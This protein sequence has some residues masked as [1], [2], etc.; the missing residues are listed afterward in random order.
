MRRARAGSAKRR[1]AKSASKTVSRAAPKTRTSKTLTKTRTSKTLTK[2][3][4]SGIASKARG[5]EY[6]FIVD[7]RDGH[8]KDVQSIMR[9]MGFRV[10]EK[11][12]I[13]GDHYGIRRFA[14]EKEANA[15]ADRIYGESPE[16]IYQISVLPDDWDWSAY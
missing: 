7:C 1:S 2:T 15:T 5:R 14:T 13:G 6:K 12:S 16:K 11:H 3:R 4:A 10:R 8:C 9:E